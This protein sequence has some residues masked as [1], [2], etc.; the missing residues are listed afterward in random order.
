MLLCPGADPG[1]GRAAQPAPNTWSSASLSTPSAGT[2]QQKGGCCGVWVAMERGIGAGPQPCQ[3]LQRRWEQVRWSCCMIMTPP[4]CFPAPKS[5]SNP[6][7]TVQVPGLITAQTKVPSQPLGVRLPA[8]PSP[9][10]SCPPRA[11]GRAVTSPSSSVTPAPVPTP[12]LMPTSHVLRCRERPGAA[13]DQHQ[14]APLVLPVSHQLCGVL[15]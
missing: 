10:S 15:E 5:C 2:R 13:L 11:Q 12:A 8:N 4:E 6:S 14:D 3:H 7:L 1:L 9:M